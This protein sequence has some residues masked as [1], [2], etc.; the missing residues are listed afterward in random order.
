MEEKTG[1][2]ENPTTYDAALLLDQNAMKVVS[3]FPDWKPGEHHGKK[4]KV[5]FT[6]PIKFRLS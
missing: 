5:E 3:S 4:V 1:T 2:E 6:V